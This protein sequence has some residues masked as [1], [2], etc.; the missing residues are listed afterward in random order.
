MLSPIT[1]VAFSAVA[2]AT[3]EVQDPSNI[4]PASDWAADNALIADYNAPFPANGQPTD[5]IG[6]HDFKHKSVSVDH[7]TWHA[8]KNDTSIVLVSKNADFAASYSTFIKSGYYSNLNWASFYG[9]NAA[10]NVANNSVA[11]LDHVNITVHNGAAN[12]YSY[13]TGTVVNV[14]NS[15]L[16]S[17]GPVSHG[18]YASG[19]GTIHAKNLQHYSGGH[20]SSAFSGDSPAGYI[21]VEDSVSH[22]RGIGSATYY[23]LGEIHATNV[24]SVSEQGP[25]VFSDGKQKIYLKDCS[26]QAGLLGGAVLFSSSERRAGAVLDLEDT[27][28]ITTGKT[29]PGLWFGNVIANARLKSVQLNTASGILAV[30][31]F[32]QIT[33]D[34]NYYGGYVDNPSMKAAEVSLNVLE[35]SLSGDLI[36]YNKSSI[37]LSLTQYSNWKGTA[38]VGYK[39]A[40]FGVSLDASSEWT[41]TADT[42]LQ[43]FTNLDTSNSNIQSRGYN[44]YYNSSA[45]ANK[46]LKSRTIKLP[47]GGKLEP[48]KNKTGY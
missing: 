26:A 33:Q 18:L 35:S 48:I 7:V 6:V 45:S 1:L 9:F 4:I 29:M 21:Y 5:L 37:S 23:A 39:S 34:F 43:N 14:T 32:S 16:Y 47:G 31:N 25:V 13:G 41:L 38:R 27:T 10:I 42:T 11:I 12:V 46:W 17:S 28:I 24:A 15:W 30:A 8:D 22:V 20:R 3:V 36:A 19:N 2:L 44:I 40:S